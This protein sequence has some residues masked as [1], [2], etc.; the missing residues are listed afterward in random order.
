MFFFGR[1]FRTAVAVLLTPRF[2]NEQSS[3]RGG[4]KRRLLWLKIFV[5]VKL[6]NFGP[7]D[8]VIAWS[9]EIRYA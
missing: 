8:F 9:R 5:F 3:R 2:S 7:I 6:G 4:V 1:L